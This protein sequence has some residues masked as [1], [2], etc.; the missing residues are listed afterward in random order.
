MKR[1]QLAS[2]RIASDGYQAMSLSCMM[3]FP[4]GLEGMAA[5]S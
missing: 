2:R 3:R 1:V 5:L 4:L